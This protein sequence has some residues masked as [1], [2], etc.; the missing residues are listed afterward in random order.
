M[1]IQ[2]TI[3]LKPELAT[4]RYFDFIVATSLALTVNS[5][6]DR[7][8]NRAVHDRPATY[9]RLAIVPGY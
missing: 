8:V 4:N 6:S 3:V 7:D 2:V 1:T 9:N 5:P